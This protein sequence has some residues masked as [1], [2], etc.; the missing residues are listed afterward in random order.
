MM[1]IIVPETC[2]A[3]NK[4]FCN[5]KP[6]VA[7]SWHFISTYPPPQI[8][9]GVKKWSRV[10]VIW[11]Y[12]RKIIWE[13]NSIWTAAL[14]GQ[15]MFEQH[16][17]AQNMAAVVL[18]SVTIVGIINVMEAGKA[19]LLRARS[20]FVSSQR[21]KNLG[22]YPP[23]ISHNSTQSAC[24]FLGKETAISWVL[25]FTVICRRAEP[26][27]NSNWGRRLAR[28]ASRRPPVC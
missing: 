22:I 10:R 27:Q 24:S 12:L 21:M 15:I 16:C 26:S 1:G 13:Q 4:H 14:N 20:S 7:S 6:S 5:K 9:K 11:R 28:S 3:S 25:T 23:T 18:N 2:W 8:H 17:S 19:N